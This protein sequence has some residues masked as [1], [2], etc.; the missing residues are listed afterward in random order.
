MTSAV[1]QV[2]ER[3][4]LPEMATADAVLSSK[5]SQTLNEIVRAVPEHP[6]F[7]LHVAV[8]SLLQ[9]TRIGAALNHFYVAAEPLTALFAVMSPAE[10]LH[11][12]GPILR[13]L[14]RLAPMVETRA[15]QLWA[16]A[17]SVLA[18]YAASA[19][20]R[21]TE[22]T[23]SLVSMVATMAHDGD[24]KVLDEFL[25]VFA[26]LLLIESHRSAATHA[27]VLHEGLK[28]LLHIFSMSCTTDAL[29]R[30]IPAFVALLCVGYTQ[31]KSEIGPMLLT[32][33]PFIGTMLQFN[34]QLVALI[35]LALIGDDAQHADDS[36]YNMMQ[37]VGQALH[38]HRSHDGSVLL[39]LRTVE[40]LSAL[41]NTK[42][43]LS[44][45]ELAGEIS[46]GV[47][48]LPE[49]AKGRVQTEVA[50]GANSALD[51]LV[52]S[53]SVAGLPA[54]GGD[55]WASAVW[56]MHMRTL[57]KVNPALAGS[58]AS[59]PAFTLLTGSSDPVEVSVCTL[60]HRSTRLVTLCVRVFSRVSFPLLNIRF[61]LSLC[62]PLTICDSS[63]PFCHAFKT[64]E[65]RSLRTFEVHSFHAST[66]AIL[67]DTSLRVFTE[68]SSRCGCT[69]LLS[70]LLQS[71]FV[72]CW[73]T[74]PRAV[75]SN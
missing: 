53:T 54:V 25:T 6:R 56:R 67:R 41:A 46:K 65:P 45:L 44:C 32:L 28:W 42:Y 74:S 2:V 64:L 63:T 43:Y 66:P 8:D 48:A 31:Q 15:S 5:I 60:I 58:T 59:Q 12:L 14:A 13:H 24:A 57:Q 17:E 11:W 35:A 61:R 69:L 34:A 71:H 73:P 39:L 47:S 50:R 70:I 10:K 1:K 51:P 33:R 7:W 49:H 30:W 68:S 27:A 36:V 3:H 38:Y 18:I 55:A 4:L 29:P 19:C 40:S 37:L 52:F 23:N 20:E 9:K 16:V 72:C 62:G 21:H 75:R 26:E 22:V